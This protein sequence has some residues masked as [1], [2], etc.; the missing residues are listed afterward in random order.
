MYSRKS[1]WR[2]VQGL[3][4]ASG[5]PD[6][7]TDSPAPD[8]GTSLAPAPDI[9]EGPAGLLPPAGG[10]PLPPSAAPAATPAQLCSRSQGWGLEE[11]KLN[12]LIGKIQ[13]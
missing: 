2:R 13:S 10:E 1:P 7:D 4:T 12:Y 3:C 8:V 9:A 6:A 11:E 5:P